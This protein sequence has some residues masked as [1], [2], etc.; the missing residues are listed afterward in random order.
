MLFLFSLYFLFTFETIMLLSSLDYNLLHWL[1]LHSMWQDYIRACHG[2]VSNNVLF[3]YSLASYPRTC[4]SWTQDFTLY[5][6]LK[7]EGRS[8]HVPQLL[9]ATWLINNFLI[10]PPPHSIY[11]WQNVC[12]FLYVFWCVIH[13]CYRYG[14]V[15]VMK[16][17]LY[18]T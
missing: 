4:G 1:E 8:L 11:G 10:S 7:G 13:F 2:F 14:T 9:L 15:P 3:I 16:V 12:I 6:I 18:L 5:P 17:L